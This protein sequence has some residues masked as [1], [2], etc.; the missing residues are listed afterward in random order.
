MCFLIIGTFFLK[1]CR[2]KIIDDIVFIHLY[3]KHFFKYDFNN[4]IML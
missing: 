3:L 4:D 1:P 2:L